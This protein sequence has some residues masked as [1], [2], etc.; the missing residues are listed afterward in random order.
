VKQFKIVDQPGALAQALSEVTHGLY[1]LTAID[2]GEAQGHPLN[3]QCP[4]AAMRVTNAPPPL[5]TGVGKKSL[6]HHLVCDTGKCVLNALDKEDSVCPDFIRRFGCQYRRDVNK[7][8]D[9]VYEKSG[10]GIP[11]LPQAKAFYEC[12]V[13]EKFI[14]DLDAR[15]LFVAS[16]DRAGVQDKGKAFSY[17]EHRKQ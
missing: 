1:V 2:G 5:A 14:L 7:F 17:N 16:V 11:I 8:E 3:G 10:S 9:F 4:D 6:T 15:T 13:I 12:T